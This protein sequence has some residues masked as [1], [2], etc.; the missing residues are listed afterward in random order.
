MWPHRAETPIFIQGVLG[1][2][3]LLGIGII[4]L[5]GRRECRSAFSR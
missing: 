3:L 5:A 4:W 1:F 2:F